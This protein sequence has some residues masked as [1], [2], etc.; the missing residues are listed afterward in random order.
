M[1]RSTDQRGVHEDLPAVTV[2]G[3]RR[4][5]AVR[6]AG[7][8]VVAAMNY[9]SNAGAVDGKSAVY[10]GASLDQAAG[11]L[12]ATNRPV[13]TRAGCPASSSPTSA[14]TQS[15][16]RATKWPTTR[17]A[18]RRPS[19]RS[20]A[21]ARSR[22]RATTRTRRGQRGPDLGH[23]VRQPVRADG[24]RRPPRRQRRRR[25]RRSPPTRPP[26][27]EHRR[28]EHVHVPHRVRRARTRSSRAACARTAAA[29]PRPSAASTGSCSRVARLTRTVPGRTR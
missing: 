29:H 19:R 22:R 3:G 15:F 24:Q 5:R 16:S 14:K 21:S 27:D 12:V 26:L 28:L 1:G 9:A 8:H 7:R 20:R 11:K 18:R 4:H 23:H 6:V 2:H 13:P 17:P 25:A 10:A